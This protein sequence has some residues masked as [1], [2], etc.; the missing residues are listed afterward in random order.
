[1]KQI[2][3]AM[4]ERMRSINELEPG[5]YVKGMDNQLHKIKSIWGVSGGRLAPPSKGG[6]GCET[7]DGQSISM[8]QA[9]GYFKKED[10][11]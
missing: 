8:W 1:M 9:R 11:E 6:F 4:R 10:V 3:V 5:D 7:E 2:V